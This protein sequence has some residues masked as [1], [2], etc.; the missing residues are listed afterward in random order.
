MPAFRSGSV[1]RIISE[2][3][4]LQRVE[5]DLGAGPEK[6][7]VLNELTG[8]VAP[9]DPVVVNT[10]AVD[11][12]LG[13]GGWHFVHWNL[14]RSEYI[15]P[16][17]GHILKARYTSLQTDVGSTEEHLDDE[18]SEMDTI[19]G[20]PV[21]AAALHSQ[22]PAVAATI[23]HLR[24][25]ARIAYVMTDGAALPLAL[26]D[27][28]AA[29]RDRSLLDTTITT[30]H[31]FGGDYEAVSVYSALA[32]ARNVAHADVAIVAMG[33]GIVGTNT[34]LGFTGIE[35]GGVLDATTGLGG[36]PIA[37]LRASFADGRGRHQG[38]SHHT[39]TTLT[40]ATQSRVEVPI[41]E[42]GD[43]VERQLR[44]ELIE[45]GV[46]E[47]HSVTT[48]AIPD[49][50]ELLDATGLH[51]TSMGRPAAADPVLFQCAAAAG[52]ASVN[53]FEPEMP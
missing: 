27:L 12:G 32:I 1:L 28:V 53:G 44:T 35:V 52:A 15:V 48:V 11:L 19:H 20:M 50:L 21:V 16:G 49:I 2:R 26:S 17:P 23:R 24:P 5:V 41:P 36:R 42:I 25:A 7:Y 33:P 37:C 38:I 43:A 10:T 45:A 46:G 14:A 39:L 29:L 22:L 18:Q 31:A 8:P 4:G 9:G 34:R 13:T 6:A 3:R 40:V 51:V 30:G 47:R